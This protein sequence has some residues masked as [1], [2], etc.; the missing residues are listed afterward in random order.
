MTPTICAFHLGFSLVANGHADI[1]AYSTGF[2][3]VGCTADTNARDNTGTTHTPEDRGV[4]IYW[5]DGTKVADE[6]QDFYN[7][8]WDDEANDKNES[9]TDGPDTSLL[10][11]Y[12]FTGCKDNGTKASLSG[13]SIALGRSNVSIGVPN[14]SHPDNGPLHSTSI[15]NKNIERPFYGLSE[16]FEV[17]P[18][19]RLSNLTIAGTAG[20]QTV[21]LSP[22]F[23]DGTFTYTAPVGNSIDEVTLTV[24]K[25]DS[26][27]TVVITGDDDTNTPDTADLDLSVGANTLAVTVTSEDTNTTLIYTVTVTRLASGAAI[28][29]REDWSLV[30]SALGVGDS[31]RLLFLSSTKRNAS[32]SSIGTYNTF[33]QG[34]AAAGHAVIQAYSD[35]FT[36]VGC[37]RAKN[38]RDNTATTYTS[39]EKGVP[40]YW[41]NGNKVADD[42][43]DFY[44]G[45]WDNESNSH[46]RNEFGINST[47]TTTVNNYPLTGCDHNGT[48]KTLTTGSVTQHRGLGNPFVRVGRLNS[49]VV[50]HG[51]LSG[52]TDHEDDDDRPMY[53]LSAVFTIVEDSDDATLS[54]LVIE[55]ATGGENI[56]LSPAFDEDTFT[57]TAAVANETNAVTLTA[58]PSHSGATVAITDDN[59]AN[60]KNEA[61][62]DLSVGAN[63]LTVT[64]T[65]EDTSVT[66]AYTI[67]VTR[68]QDPTV[69][70]PSYQ[71]GA[72]S[73]AG[74]AKVTSSGSCSSAASGE[75][76]LRRTSPITT[77]SSRNELPPAIPTSK[78]T[79]IDS[80]QLAA[81]KQSTPATI[82]APPIPTPTRASPSTGSTATRSPTN[83]RTSTTAPG[84]T[85]PMVRTS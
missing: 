53:G 43:E 28:P 22:T 15:S 32:S 27:A 85:K 31:F 81:P 52:A 45:S 69:R 84:T 58:T 12:P 30:P 21:V 18:D 33:I 34:R 9:G 71:H 66:E 46:D 8:N 57:Y 36:A 56:T 51:P 35:G 40:I 74:S 65:A 76:A 2:G 68:A 23:D 70:P 17:A 64:V 48:E 47:N 79:A 50:G 38:A 14:S 5:I 44:D 54:N 62:L 11:N 67:T 3:V 42:Y 10:G 41:L 19:A 1:Q 37:T 75:T 49:P 20:G 73:P 80:R 77:P 25:N 26:N 82:R 63:T 60:T 61:N 29:V 24:T 4:P 6:Y 39:T 78:P 72:L 7:G 55:G 83:T 59:D 16:V 13:N